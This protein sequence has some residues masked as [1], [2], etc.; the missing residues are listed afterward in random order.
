MKKLIIS[1]FLTF[2]IGIGFAQISKSFKNDSL[3]I[4]LRKATHDTT[5]A[6]LILEILNN[7]EKGNLKDMN[8]G[9]FDKVYD[10]YINMFDVCE[11]TE[12][13]LLF[14]KL[15]SKGDYYE[16]FWERYNNHTFN[17]GVL[18]GVTANIEEQLH[19]FK[20]AYEMAKVRNSLWQQ[21]TVQS[22]IAFAFQHDNKV[23]SAQFYI[24]KIFA[25]PVD[26][27]A[28]YY[29]YVFYQAG[30]IKLE[31]GN[32]EQAKD[33]FS[34]GIEN[35]L[36]NS[37]DLEIGLSIN[38]LGLSKV[39]QHLNKRDSSYYYGIKSL[40]L[41]KEIKEVQVVKVDLATAYENMFQHF[42]RFSQRDSAFKYLQLANIER[43]VFT[44]KT[45]SN[46]AT[47]Q[48]V[49]LK[50]QL[51]LKDLTRQKI[52]A[53][54]R[55]RMYILL[56][57]LFVF[58]AFG[59]VLLY[60]YLQKK[61]ANVLLASQ[62]EEIQST[63]LRLKSTQAQLIQSEKMASLGELTAG[64]A[65]EIQNPLNF[66]N[67]FSELSIDLTK[68]LGD[69]VDKDIIDKGLT[70]ELMSD[71]IHN[72]EKINDHGKRASNI[73]RGMLEHSRK[74]A[75]KK[76][77]TDIN[78]LADEYLRLA[79]HSLKAKD[80]D[81]NAT[82]ETHFDSNLPKIDV[83]PQDIGRVILN[84][85]TNAFYACDERSR[86]AVN[87]RIKKGEEGYEPKVTV[88][89]Q[90]AA[91]NHLIIAIKDNGSG[92]PKDIVDKIFQP[93]FTTKPTGQGT[94]LGLSL[95]YDIVKAHGGELKVVTNKREGCE[96]IITLP[97]QTKQNDGP[98]L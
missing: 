44:K 36:K 93:F 67:N 9:H 16:R 6:I 27:F 63:L 59:V 23:D 64:I 42:Q 15:E 31:A 78:A 55:M 3:Q 86:S 34:K 10:A 60:S 25:N 57:A 35:T 46:L 50:R 70:K 43:A 5:K 61:K 65:H 85:I 30:D 39:Y 26:P 75:G 18:M 1:I 40:N 17:Y 71:L 49:L 77:P 28:R 41:L 96:F 76:E 12:N 13:Q 37:F 81:F 88:T 19:Y 11:N 94:G 74:S 62:K 68:E 21:T 45:I 66:V 7:L 32:Y 51:A 91:N 58:V 84:L 97:I 38:S 20:L 98:T 4:Q 47:F 54:G 69:E 48:Q 24:D 87:E 80:K 82:M 90:L 95:S 52:E 53:E 8:N 56:T 29:F 2:I 72:Q 22:N 14:K 73:I 83:V 89:T 33:L 92:I 79:Y